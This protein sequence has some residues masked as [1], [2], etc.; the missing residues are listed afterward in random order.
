M[1]RLTTFGKAV[2]ITAAAFTLVGGCHLMN[3]QVAEGCGNPITEDSRFTCGTIVR[4]NQDTATIR[5]TDGNEWQIQQDR[6]P[7]D[8]YGY[9]CIQFNTKGTANLFDDEIIKVWQEV[10]QKPCP[11]R[12]GENVYLYSFFV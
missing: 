11:L 9:Y 5:T 7:W 12:A 6:K 3:G 2:I 8:L 4:M 1:R 10:Q